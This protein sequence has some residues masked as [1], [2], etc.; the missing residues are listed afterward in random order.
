MFS[1]TKP[2]FIS[3]FSFS[4]SLA[5]KCV[6]LNNE[7][8]MIRSFLIDLSLAELKYYQFII[9]LDKC[10]ESSNSVDDLST[11]NLFSVKQKII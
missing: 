7:P 10:S 1:P 3:L 2:V 8:C 5:T 6:Q 11:K 9:N 4:K